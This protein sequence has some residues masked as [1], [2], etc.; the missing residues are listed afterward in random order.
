MRSFSNLWYWIALAVTWSTASHWVLGVPFDMVQQA[1]RRGGQAAEDMVTLTGV[2]VRRLVM[3]GR[4]AGAIVALGV[5][6]VLSSLVVLGF[7]Y[8]IEFAQ[9]LALLAVPLALV[10]GLSLR[11]AV[12]IEPVL[13]RDPAPE[14][15]AR[16]LMRHRVSVQLVGVVAITFTALWGMFQNLQVSVLH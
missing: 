13:A 4:E 7:G 5:A 3:I 2:N 15:V 8:G 9:A 12:R 6:F 11:M 16:L 10:G 14:E 1:R